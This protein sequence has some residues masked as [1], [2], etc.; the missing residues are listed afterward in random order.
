MNTKKLKE[1][2]WWT[3]I[4]DENLKVFDIIMY[5]EFGTSYNSYVL[6]SGQTTVLF[7]TAKVKFKEEWLDKIK[8]VCDPTKID[9]L[10]MSHTEP[11]HAGSVETL[12]DI[13]PNLKIVA[14][15]SAISFLKEIVNRDFYSMAVKDNQEMVLGEKTLRFLVVPNLHWPDTMYTYIEQDKTLVTC[16]SFGSHYGFQDVLLSKVTD[17]EGYQRATKYYFDCIIAPFKGFMAKALARVLK[18]DIELIC[19][20]HG[21]VLDTNLDRVFQWY[22][23]WCSDVNPNAKKT[24]IIPYVSSYGYTKILSEKIAEG[25]KESGD[26]D[27]RSY[28]MVEAEQGKVLDELY[29]ADGILF[30]TPT[31]LGDALKPIWDLTSS[32]FAVTHGKKLAA[33]FGSYGWSGEGVPHILQRL[34]Q[35]KMKV[36]DD[37]FRVRFKP[38]EVDLINAFEYGYNFGCLLQNKENI[39]KKGVRKLVKCLVCGEI[40]DASLELCPVCGVG[41]DKWVEVEIEEINY[42][43]NTDKHYLI[44]GG[45]VAAVSAAGA[46]RARDLTGKI[47]MVSAEPYLPINRPMLTKSML[48]CLHPEEI[49]INGSDW[50]QEKN[51]ELK[52]SKLVSNID[53]KAKLVSLSDGEALSYDKLIYALGAEGFQP[54]IPGLDKPEV[55]SIRHVEDVVKISSLL[56]RVKNVVVIGGGVLGLEAAWE[57]KKANCSVTVLEL[58]PQ[59]MGR[60]LDGDTAEK[61]MEQAKVQSIEILTGVKIEGI[62]GEGQVSGV[63]LG[64]GTIVSADLVILSTGVSANTALA[65]EAGVEI[66]RGIVVNASMATNVPDLYACGDCA[67]FNGINYAIWPEALE[68]GKVAGSNAAGDTVSYEAISAGMSFHGM[69]TSLFAIGDVGKDPQKTYKTVEFRDDAKHEYEKYWFVNGQLTGAI[70]LGNVDKIASVTEAVEQHKLFHRM[71]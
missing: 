25:I 33:A 45:G 22:K 7:E 46:I 59:L 35:L 32:M 4:V 48:A 44:L 47:T 11:D 71:F 23:E 8:E 26:I 18:L 41:P 40:F 31:I 52:L 51:I 69:G 39:K 2:L 30:G 49:A 53:P 58:A 29:Y 63:R 50:Y 28:D 24:V 55:V 61:L 27:V 12:L 43:S 68:Q 65:R 56:E 14:T 5:T 16:D 10:V 57:M 13:S 37:G 42:Q 21:P 19:T 70:L 66:E 34:R 1:N 38:S 6:K 17:E 9:Y 54:P 3:G 15:S 62:E 64:D 20:G 60:Q 36:P 67:Q